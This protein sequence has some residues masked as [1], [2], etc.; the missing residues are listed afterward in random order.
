MN[1]KTIGGG[2][3]K[4]IGETMLTETF[5]S[6]N[7]EYNSILPK[8][9]LTN[10]INLVKNELKFRH[11]NNMYEDNKNSIWARSIARIT[12]AHKWSDK[13]RN[14]LDNAKQNDIDRINKLLIQ[15]IY[16]FIKNNRIPNGDDPLT[17]FDDIPPISGN[18]GPPKPFHTIGGGNWK[19]T[20]ETQLTNT[21]NYQ[22]KKYDGKLNPQILKDAI[23][24]AKQQIEDVHG[25]RKP[26]NWITGKLADEKH[27]VMIKATADLVA[28]IERS[29]PTGPAAPRPAAPRPPP[30]DPS[31]G[32]KRKTKKA[33]RSRRYSRRRN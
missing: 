10:A 15:Q 2:E 33:R 1:S 20:V 13:A 14:E 18:P 4:K 25:K 6:W 12:L 29:R 31:E 24:R 19:N 32:G 28:A 21:F 3:W 27:E 11:D 26:L 23:A 8:E 16:F 22:N 30:F 5:N 7:Q 17:K 9:L